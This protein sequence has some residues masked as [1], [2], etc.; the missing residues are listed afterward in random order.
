MEANNLPPTEVREPT[1]EEV[2]RLVHA[3]EEQILNSPDVSQEKK[4]AILDFY[5][6]K[7]KEAD[8]IHKTERTT[9]GIE[10]TPRTDSVLLDPRITDVKYKSFP[11]F[12]GWSKCIVDES[13][14]AEIGSLKVKWN[15]P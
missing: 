3:D 1:E 7:L 5:R 15:Q 2:R 9:D 8:N 13:R 6:E 10:E 11:S 12:S 14:W 4:N